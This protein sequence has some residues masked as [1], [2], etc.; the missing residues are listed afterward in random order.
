[1]KYLIISLLT[2][3]TLG[4][5]QGQQEMELRPDGLVVPK[6]TNAQRPASPT[7]GHFL[8]NTDQGQFEYYNGVNWVPFSSS[9]ISD[10]IQN[11]SIT[12][13]A[14]LKCTNKLSN[15]N[16]APS[17]FITLNLTP[18]GSSLFSCIKK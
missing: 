2:V 1:M 3:F 14:K 6:I 5:I 15:K 7:L 8:Y 16:I 18:F 4:I 9:A 10:R 17:K 13:L 11:S 12:K